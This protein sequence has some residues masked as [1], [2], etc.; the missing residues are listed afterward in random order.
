MESRKAI[1]ETPKTIRVTVD[2]DVDILCAVEEIKVQL[3]L[4][5]RGY[6]INQLLRELL[7]IDDEDM[8][9][10]PGVKEKD[11]LE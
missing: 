10:E 11:G 3:G 9:Q 7:I 1:G 4:G 5:S 2:I 6:V 8:P